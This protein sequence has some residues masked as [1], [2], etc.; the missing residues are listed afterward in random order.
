MTTTVFATTCPYC[1]AKQDH[2]SGAGQPQRGDT[3]VCFECLGASVYAE[4][5]TLRPTDLSADEEAE[6]RPYRHAIMLMGGGQAAAP[7]ASR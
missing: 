2:H 1:G 4:D 3:S 7:R 5:L 6:L